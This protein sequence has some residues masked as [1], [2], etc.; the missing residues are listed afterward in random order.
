MDDFLEKLVCIMLYGP[1]ICQSCRLQ[2]SW[3]VSV[4]FNNKR[5]NNAMK[6][7]KV[8]TYQ[9]HDQKPEVISLMQETLEIQGAT[10]RESLIFH[11]ACQHY[12]D[13]WEGG[14]F[15]A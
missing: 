10:F 5:N 3:S 13:V 11:T 6:I 2:E 15:C 1:A 4:V 14:D 8:Q 7:T 9:A 12:N